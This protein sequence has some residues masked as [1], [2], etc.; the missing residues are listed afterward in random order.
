[1]QSTKNGDLMVLMFWSSNMA[2]T[3]PPW[4]N[5]PI[6]TSIAVLNGI[7]RM[8]GNLNSC[9]LENLAQHAQSGTMGTRNLNSWWGTR[10]CTRTP[11]TMAM[12]GVDLMCSVL[13]GNAVR[14][15]GPRISG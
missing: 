4:W 2:G 11:D 3:T 8:Y 10:L 15:S 1:M 7:H 14:T 13:K 5:L 9:A 12:N 6:K